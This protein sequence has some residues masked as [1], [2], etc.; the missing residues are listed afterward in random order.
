MA[1]LNPEQFLA[2]VA[3]QPL[4]PAYLFLG[5]EGYFRKLCREALLARA[6]PGDARESGFT[7][8]DLE[9]RSLSEILDDARSFSLFARDR[10]IWISS[11]QLALPRRLVVESEDEDNSKK[12]GASGLASYLS[13]AAD[14]TVLV[15]ECSC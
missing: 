13:H 10:V 8:V 4:A 12:P 2:R 11:A 14:G 15:F 3:K 6:L 1:L 7:Q 5:P 9:E